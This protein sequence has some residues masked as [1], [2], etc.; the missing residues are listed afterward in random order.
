MRRGLRAAAFGASLLVAAGM[1]AWTRFGPELVVEDA[2]RTRVLHRER[3]VPGATFMLEYV[4]S[5]ER[6]PVR[7]TFRV[8]DDRTLTVMET[9]FGG[10]GPGLPE[11][12]RD[13]DWRIAGGMIVHRPRE[14]TLPELRLRVSP[15]ARQQ[16]TTPSGRQLDLATMVGEGGLLLVQVR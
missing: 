12:T 13:D 14:T 7:G 2:G 3:V 4:H 10:F 16:L 6:V 5:S 15:V 9:A 8:E 1:A 11:L